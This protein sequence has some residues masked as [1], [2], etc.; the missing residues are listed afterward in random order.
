MEEKTE[1]KPVT[2]AWTPDQEINI[3]LT[4]VEFQNLQILANLLNKIVDT[5]VDDKLKLG[6][7]KP[8]YEEDIIDQ[9]LR[10]DFWSI[11]EETKT[12]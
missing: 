3:K 2:I 1:K 7:F 6:E 4:G 8:V 10:P 5:T 9:K 11:K 12:N